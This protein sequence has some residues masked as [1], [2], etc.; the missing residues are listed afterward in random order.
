LTRLQKLHAW[1]TTG[2]ILLPPI[3]PVAKYLTGGS[4]LAAFAIGAV[5]M[6]IVVI[7]AKPSAARAVPIASGYLR[8]GNG[9]CPDYGSR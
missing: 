6:A 1:E 3:L 4:G 2:L 8:W 9:S 5:L 7:G